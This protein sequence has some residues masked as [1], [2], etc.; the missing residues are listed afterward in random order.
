MA[1]VTRAVLYHLSLPQLNQPRL[2][3]CRSPAVMNLSMMCRTEARHVAQIV[4]P[5]F[6]KR[7]DVVNLAV[8]HFC[9]VAEWWMRTAWH[10]TSETGSHLPDGDDQGIT[11]DTLVW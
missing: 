9:C 5:A 8:G 6:G 4:G 1:G 2:N 3:L 7:S 11:G 10:F